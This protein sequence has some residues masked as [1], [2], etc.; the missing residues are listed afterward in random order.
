M[1]KTMKNKC[2]W[3]AIFLAA[4]MTVCALPITALSSFDNTKALPL[5]TPEEPSSVAPYES[6]VIDF[7]DPVPALTL[8]RGELSTEALLDDAYEDTELRDAFTKHYR[9]SDDLYQAVVY[10]EAVHYLQNGEWQEVDN[11]LRYQS[12]TGTYQAQAWRHGVSFAQNASSSNLISFSDGDYTISWSVRFI[13][14]TVGGAEVMQATENATLAAQGEALST[15]SMATVSSVSMQKGFE[16]ATS[17]IKYENVYQD[18]VDLRYSVAY[19]K[20]EEDIILTARPNFKSYQLVFQTGGL[21]VQKNA[22]NQLLFLNAEG[23]AVF[24]MATPWMKDSEANV[25]DA[26]SISVVQKGDVALVTYTPDM[27]WL[28]DEARV[29]PVLIDPSFTS[30]YY[31]SNYIDTYVADDSTVSTTRQ[32]ETTMTVGNKNGKN[33]YAYIKILNLPEIDWA[34]VTKAS[35]EFSVNTTSSPALTLSEI[36]NDWNASTLSGFNQPSSI[37]IATGVTGTANTALGT[38]RYSIDLANWITEI[39]SEYAEF[40]Y[41]WENDMYGFKIGYTTSTNNNYALIYSS[42]Y[43]SYSSRPIWNITYSYT[44]PSALADGAVY[45]FQSLSSLG[46][47]LT[48][49]HNPAAYSGAYLSSAS[50]SVTQKFVLQ[51]DASSGCFSICPVR[52]GTTTYALSYDS[53]CLYGNAYYSTNIELHAYDTSSSNYEEEQLWVIEPI[54]SN[55]FK[56]VSAHDSSRALTANG[57]SSATLAEYTGATNQHWQ[58]ES[59]SAPISVGIRIVDDATHSY[60]ESASPKYFNYPVYNTDEF[61][62]GYSSSNPNVATVDSTTGLVTIKKAGITT[63]TATVEDGA[64]EQYDH[65]VTLYVYLANGT[66]YFNNVSNSYRIYLQDLST[67]EDAPRKLWNSTGEPDSR[68]ELFK[69]KHLGNGVYSIRSLADSSMG[70]RALNTSTALTNATIGY[71]DSDVINGEKWK[72]DS[73]ANGYYIY[74]YRGK[75]QTVTSPSLA[76]NGSEV[77]L[78]AYSSTN[79]LQN[80]TITKSTAQYHGVTIKNITNALAVGHKYDFEAALYSTYIDINGQN[81]FT[82]SVAN[83]TGSATI[84]S[85]TGELTGISSGT[86][87]VTAKYSQN[88]LTYWTASCTV[89]IIPVPNGTYFFRTGQYDNYMQIDNDAEITDTGSILELWPFD[90]DANQKWMIEY[91]NNGYYK[92][93]STA[94]GFA[95]TAPSTK[96]SSVTQ[97]LYSDSLLTQQWLITIVGDGTYRL[98]PRSN[99]TYYLAAGEGIFTDGGRNVE[100]RE[101]QSNKQD[102]W[103]LLN[104]TGSDVLLL[105]IEDDGHDHKTVYGEI[106]PQLIDLGY[107]D[108]NYLITTMIPKADVLDAMEQS[109]IFV[110]RS[111]G[112]ANND[113]TYIALSNDGTS[114]LHANDIYDFS[115]N[116]AK[117]DLSNCDLL[118]FI[119]CNTATHGTQS[120]PHAAVAAGASYSIGFTDGID[121]SLANLWVKHFF[122]HYHDG[123]SVEEAALEATEDLPLFITLP[124]FV[125][126]SND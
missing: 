41:Y 126:S 81:G 22:Q 54:S 20:V 4:W 118:L 70:W 98:S 25:S 102:E 103:Y 29:Y 39:N 89:T 35:F 110:S 3:I 95:L 21:T 116:T 46:S 106:M 63:I 33:Y 72:I 62:V 94:S 13:G 93:I 5:A 111:H 84:N 77:S 32:N 104:I 114:N 85:S 7:K 16:K 107:T 57:S 23:T 36:C 1:K 44:P 90:S 91:L 28:C 109:K 69:I 124:Y 55:V 15:S 75:N 38:S 12:E 97:Q 119:A 82:W 42:E 52:T 31:T 53:D 83:G 11:T 105:G 78:S 2:R 66:Y 64:E 17:Q 37:S 58:L 26:F 65:S 59:G 80:W 92:I 108:F 100:M 76:R 74:N 71:Y 113:G 48:V 45:K 67:E 122:T 86:V 121:C 112:A 47:Y 87:T 34:Y 40:G 56:I 19:G 125:V 14:Q 99:L 51:Q 24:T 88:S 50:Y 9:L 61:L 120:L 101:S 27:E 8:N 60:S 68:D 18:A 6:E 73:N 43:S 96:D 10:P 79:T 123:K 117:V 30:Q 49:N 115:T